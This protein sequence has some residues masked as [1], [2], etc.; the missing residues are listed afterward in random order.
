MASK[1][2][3]TRTSSG[4]AGKAHNAPIAH[5]RGA[6]ERSGQYVLGAHETSVAPQTRY[7]PEIEVALPQK[8]PF[9]HGRGEDDPTGLKS[10]GAHV[11]QALMPP[12]LKNP[13][14]H[15]TQSVSA[16]PEQIEETPCPV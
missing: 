16:T 8:L 5:G 4:D 6:T 12:G 9:E 1:R 13:A 11:S 15:A 10:P 2:S 3:G 14:S 7:P